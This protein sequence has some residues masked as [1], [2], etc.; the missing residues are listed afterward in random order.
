M[1]SRHPQWKGPRKIDNDGYVY[2][3]IPTHPFC[4][5]KKQVFEHRLVMEKYLGRYLNRKEVVHH[6]NDIKDDNR[7]ENLQLFKDN[8]EHMNFHYSKRLKF[9]TNNCGRQA[10]IKF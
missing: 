3:Y 1:G 9:Q 5:R 10:T 8:E 6:I 7:I 2:I 4:N